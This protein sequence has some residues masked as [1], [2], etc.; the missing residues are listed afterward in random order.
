VKLLRATI[1]GFRAF[2]E[3]AEVDLS[4]DVTILVGPNGTGKTSLLDAL[5]WGITGRLKRVGDSHERV[6]SLYAP[7]GLAR[8]SLTLVD[9][10]GTVS[11]VRTLLEGQTNLSLNMGGR[12]VEGPAADVELVRRLWDSG[13]SSATPLDDLHEVMTRSVYLQ[14]DLVRQFVDRDSAPERFDAIGRL[15]G[16]GRIADFQN[17]LVSSRKAWATVMGQKEKDVAEADRRLA[18]V[19]AD[20]ARLGRDS[21]ESD[22]AS[23]WTSWWNGLLDKGL[24]VRPIPDV[25]MPNAAQVLEQML[26]ALQTARSSAQRK[27][28]T[29]PQIREAIVQ[30]AD[31]AEIPADE[32]EK[33]RSAVLS[34]RATREHLKESVAAAEERDAAARAVLL[35]QKD[36]ADEMQSLAQL[37]LRHL[38]THCPVCEQPINAKAV[39]TRL[40]QLIG[41]DSSKQK[42]VSSESPQ[43]I[44]DLERASRDAQKAERALEDAL[45]ANKLI[46]SRR[47]LLNSQLADIELET[48]DLRALDNLA[49]TL[50]RQVADISEA[51]KS[52]EA[53]SLAIVRLSE[54][55]K[56]ED[57]IQQESKAVE[58]CERAR[59]L[60]GDYKAAHEESSRIIEAVRAVADDAV[61]RQIERIGPLLQKIYTRID[62]HPTFRIAELR[63]HVSYGK[64][65]VETPVTDPRGDSLEVDSPADIFSSSQTSALAVSIFLAM[66]LSSDG[67]PLHTAIL[68]D[69]LQSLD[70]I[71][72]L[73]LLDVLRR[74][75]ERRQLIIST[76]DENFAALLRRKF[77]PIEQGQRTSLVTLRNWERSG[78]SLEQSVEEDVPARLQVVS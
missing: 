71:N 19:R 47:I 55:G 5:L 20:L 66:N 54:E 49:S 69:P 2:T 10:N 51:Y 73:G 24:G 16:V 67:M 45:N 37:A 48:A 14:Q 62:P 12:S 27:L 44:A 70:D 40:V 50:N 18:S 1:E 22:A 65:R 3:R 43:L 41:G 63:S 26:R 78:V 74:A 11:L 58:I 46:A 4:A 35:S 32:I 34:A 17:R 13:S 33:R 31:V 76:H 38:S 6:L 8:V 21:K 28:S 59:A 7:A 60:L 68:D 39:E 61:N 29:L 64:G 56:R 77:R 52:G 53:L 23:G 36:T 30:L 25:T 75:R 15:I 9:E 42:A 57:L 72:M